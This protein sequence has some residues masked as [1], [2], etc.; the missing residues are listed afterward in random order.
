VLEGLPG[1]IDTLVFGGDVFEFWWEWRTA[2]PRLH[3]EILLALRKTSDAGVRIR[4]IAGNHDFAIGRFL[5]DFLGATIDPDG[6][7]MDIGG[8]RWLLLHGDGMPRSDR[9]DRLVRRVLRSRSAQRIWNLLPP[10]IAFSLA[11]SVG[12]TTRTLHPGPPPNIAEYGEAASDWIARWNLAG[13]VH[14][15]THRPLLEPLGDG[16]HVNNGD[17][18]KDRFAVWIGPE[19]RVRLVDCRKEGHPWLSN[20]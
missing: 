10:D 16:F 14:G 5:A 11:G 20:T 4:F 2:I 15:H 8:H 12:N 18:L 6:F 13:V 17:W 3:M 9:L 19:R 7:C 1:R